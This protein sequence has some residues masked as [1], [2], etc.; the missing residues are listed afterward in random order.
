[1]GNDAGIFNVLLLL[2]GT[3]HMQ[4]AHRRRGIPPD[5]VRDTVLD[6]KLQLELEDYTKQHGRLGVSLRILNWLMNHWRGELYRLGRLQFIPANFVG[7]VRAFRHR[8]EGTVIALCEPGARYR[9][10]GQFN[11]T[12]GVFDPEGAWVSTLDIGSKEIIGNPVSVRGC[13]LK[14]KIRLR[15]SEWRQILGRRDPTLDVHIAA[16]SPMTFDA[17]GD[18]IRQALEFFPKYFP[19]K[20]FVALACYSWILDSQF[21]ELLP[22]T[23]NLVRFMRE[24]YLFPIHDDGL[25]VFTEVFGGVP[26]DIRTVP[27][28]TTM[29]RAFAEHVE[30]GGHFHGGGCLL[31]PEDFRWGA[32]HYR[33]QRFTPSQPAL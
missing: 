31:F 27:R 9:A 11:G 28:N 4:E 7:K 6:L 33:N 18:S 29:Q 12:A 8:T 16:G 30:R 21:E 14:E 26:Q 2:S 17:C 24:V 23:S 32:Q 13:A 25:R 1:L 15:A 10:D 20:P 3:P 19:D 5:I 22:P